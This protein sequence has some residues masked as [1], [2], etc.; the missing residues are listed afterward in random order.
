MIGCTML[1]KHDY[2]SIA[3]IIVRMQDV[4]RCPKWQQQLDTALHTMW[5]G[6]WALLGDTFGLVGIAVA[7]FLVIDAFKFDF[8]MWMI[9][10]QMRR[11]QRRS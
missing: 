5:D 9:R 7:A 8:E 2:S 4:Q 3:E 1:E 11:E 10:R 6:Y